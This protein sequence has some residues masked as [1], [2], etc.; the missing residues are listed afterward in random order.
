MLIH[1]FWVL[2][3]PNPDGMKTAG[4]K[5]TNSRYYY[6]D[7]RS[8]PLSTLASHHVMHS[9]PLRHRRRTVMTTVSILFFF[10]LFFFG[11][12]LRYNLNGK[13]KQKATTAWVGIIVASRRYARCRR[14]W[15]W[16]M[17][18]RRRSNF[19]IIYFQRFPREKKVIRY[20]PRCTDPAEK[21]ITKT[22][23]RYVDVGVRA[24]KRESAWTR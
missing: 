1:R 24:R 13:K 21:Y 19:R 3:V 16:F 22:T 7:F 4:Q 15:S 6:W 14:R 11:R 2:Q 12:S 17:C 23:R 8:P 10:L 5:E 18:R 9:T 20:L